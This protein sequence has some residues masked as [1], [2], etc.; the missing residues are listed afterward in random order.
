MKNHGYGKTIFDHFVFVKKFSNGDFIILLL[1]VDDILIVGHDTER[2]E[3]LKGELSKSFV[4][5]DLGPTKEIA[6]GR[7][8]SFGYLK[9]DTEKVLQ[10]FNM[11]KSKSVCSPLACHFKLSWK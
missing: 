11:S 5:K 8:G 1:Y 7:M 9:K 6:I 4:M 3:N 10:N 2:I